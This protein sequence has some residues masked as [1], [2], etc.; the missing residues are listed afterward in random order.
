MFYLKQ[1]HFWQ[2]QLEHSII[3]VKI[4]YM[5]IYKVTKSYFTHIRTSL[6]YCL[7]LEGCEM[8]CL[9]C[10]YH[11]YGHIRDANYKG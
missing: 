7:N 4:Y 8:V 9:C 2:T 5:N 6:C 1:L 11:I 10:E 3:H